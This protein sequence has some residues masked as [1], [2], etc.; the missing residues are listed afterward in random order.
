MLFPRLTQKHLP[1]G[2]AGP[3]KGRNMIREWLKNR[4]AKARAERQE[5]DRER[6][7]EQARDIRKMMYRVYRDEYS[8]ALAIW[9]ANLSTMKKPR[10][11]R[12][13]MATGDGAIPIPEWW[14]IQYFQGA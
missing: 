10:I 13:A 2:Q 11:L 8:R 1:P 4:K 6:W 14:V 5:T 7:E 9:L 12:E 3:R